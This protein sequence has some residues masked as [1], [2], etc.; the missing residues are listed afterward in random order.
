MIGGERNYLI[1]VNYSHQP[2]IYKT[3]LHATDPHK[4]K[5]Q[6]LIKQ[7]ESLGLKHFDDLKKFIKFSYYAHYIY[8]NID[9]YHTN[10]DGKY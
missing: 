9:E 4:A 10:K 2:E 7:R 5:Y 3:Y 6:M 1:K 8:K